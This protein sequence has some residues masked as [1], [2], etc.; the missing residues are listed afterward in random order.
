MAT[1]RLAGS[2]LLS[3]VAE[4]ANALSCTVKSVSTGANMLNDFVE[5]ARSQQLKRIKGGAE[6][7]DAEVKVTS[8]LRIAAA[9]KQ[10][11]D[12]VKANPDQEQL[13]R[14]AW[15]DVEAALA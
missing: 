13:I 12:Y 4:T 5:N 11:A 8:T 6:G 9:H 10:L 7:F 14:D 15:K 2:A 3:T 1:A